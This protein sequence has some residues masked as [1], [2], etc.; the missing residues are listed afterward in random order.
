MYKK[1]LVFS[2]SFL[3]PKNQRISLKISNIMRLLP[4]LLLLSWTNAQIDLG[5]IF[6][7]KAGFAG[8]RINTQSHGLSHS[9]RIRQL[10]SLTMPIRKERVQGRFKDKDKCEN[11][12]LVHPSN[13]FSCGK[14][15]SRETCSDKNCCWD[16]NAE[17]CYKQVC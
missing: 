4:N 11:R 16:S 7:K 14:S 15:R 5:R 2:W 12:C 3:K 17:M 6:D 9:D 13:R 8:L 1:I 10:L